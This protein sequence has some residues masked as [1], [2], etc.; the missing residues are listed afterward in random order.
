MARRVLRV[1]S[2]AAVVMFFGAEAASAT[3]ID[4]VQ[5]GQRVATAPG[6]SGTS[7]DE[8]WEVHD[9]EL[10]DGRGN[11]VMVTILRPAGWVDQA[12]GDGDGVFW[13]DIDEA[14]IH[15]IAR[16]VGSRA[17]PAV[18]DGPGRVVLATMAHLARNVVSL[19]LSDWA[20]AVEVT[21]SHPFWSL[22]RAAWVSVGDLELG[23]RV[24]TQRGESVVES[25]VRLPGLHWVFNLEVEGDHEYFAGS[26]FARVHNSCHDTDAPGGETLMTI[27]S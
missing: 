7:V 16:V 4:Q 13:L 5:V 21:D 22:D 19:R 25:R 23:E 3:P 20:E 10:Y 24:Q 14:G 11:P 18:A 1:A 27:M 2:L 6:L 8:T 15:G 17:P 12:D 9:L 26:G